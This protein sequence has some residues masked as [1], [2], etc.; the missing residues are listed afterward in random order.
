MLAFMQS[1]F[2]SELKAPVQQLLHKSYFE[3]GVEP[4]SWYTDSYETKWSLK[5]Y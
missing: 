4:L 5:I 1:N 2:S 3:S